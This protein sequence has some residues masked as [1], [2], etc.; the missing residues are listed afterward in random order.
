MSILASKVPNEMALTKFLDIF[1]S[2]YKHQV[3]ISELFSFKDIVHITNGKNG[4]GRMIRL[5]SHI[6]QNIENEV[7]LVFAAHNRTR[8]KKKKSNTS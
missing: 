4:Q 8:K 1:E 5:V 6:Q 7:S 2:K 3:T